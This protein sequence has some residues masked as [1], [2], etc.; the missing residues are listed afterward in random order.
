[1]LLD[2][3]VKITSMAYSSVTGELTL[4]YNNGNV[5]TYRNVPQ[6]VYDEIRNNGK[7]LSNSMFESLNANYEKIQMV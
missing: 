7:Q 1:M 3:T 4:K 6:G 2:N 5:V